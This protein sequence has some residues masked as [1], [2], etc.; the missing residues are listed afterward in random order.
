LLVLHEYGS[1]APVALG[2]VLITLPSSVFRVREPERARP[3]AADG[4]SAG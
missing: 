2:L 3:P 4:E 1:Q